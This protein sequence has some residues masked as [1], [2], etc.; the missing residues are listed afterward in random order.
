MR[1][2]ATL[3]QIEFTYWTPGGDRVVTLNH[4]DVVAVMY[5]SAEAEVVEWFTHDTPRETAVNFATSGDTFY[6]NPESP[7]NAYALR[8]RE[9]FA[10]CFGLAVN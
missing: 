1:N 7:I 8:E 10:D 2:I 3:E 5:D 9:L 6:F 4:A